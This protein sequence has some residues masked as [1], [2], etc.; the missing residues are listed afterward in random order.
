MSIASGKASGSMC[1]VA[2]TTLHLPHQIQVPFAVA[3]H[4]VS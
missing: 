2:N 1:R 3:D 4:K